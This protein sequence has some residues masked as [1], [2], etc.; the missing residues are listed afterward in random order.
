MKKYFMIAIMAVAALTVNAQSSDD[1]K[2][3][4]ITPHMGVGYAN[5]S[6]NNNAYLGNN[7]NFAVAKI[8]GEFEMMASKNFGISAGIDLTYAQSP[9]KEFSYNDK[10]VKIN[11]KASEN[12]M[13]MNVPVLAQYHVGGFTFKAGVQANILLDSNIK[14]TSDL[15]TTDSSYNFDKTA[16]TKDAYNTV[17]WSVPV[18]VSYT[19]KVP[20]TVGLD[21]NIPVS[22]LSKKDLGVNQK[23]MPVML[24]VGYRF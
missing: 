20:V 13:F 7:N 2:K 19:F 18:G 1:D 14:Y 5:L 24:T 17:S 9:N 3:F 10:D 16:S 21:C 6:N 15:K 23:F 11:A 4:H 8:G 22:S 12:F